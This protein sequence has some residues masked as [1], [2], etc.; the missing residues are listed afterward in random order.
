MKEINYEYEPLKDFVEKVSATFNGIDSVIE[1]LEQEQAKLNDDL[2]KLNESDSYK[3][4]DIKR[5][6]RIENELTILTAAIEKAK[7]ERLEIQQKKWNEVQ[8]ESS[9]LLSDYDNFIQQ[10]L[11]EEEA[12]IQELL[13]QANQ[14]IKEIGKV[15]QNK[16]SHFNRVVINPSNRIIGKV[17]NVDCI[18]PNFVYY[19]DSLEKRVA[20]ILNKTIK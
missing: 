5:K 17:G 15:K 16:S 8:T 13:L 1:E 10:Q 11:K 3:I 14:K 20:R 18:S 7:Q 12:A 4:E 19:T 9:Q 2:A 6:A